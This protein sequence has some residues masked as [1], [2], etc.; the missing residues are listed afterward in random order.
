MLQKPEK[1]SFLCTLHKK[2]PAKLLFFV[3]YSDLNIL[4]ARVTMGLPER[5]RHS[6]PTESGAG[7]SGGKEGSYEKIFLEYD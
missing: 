1:A 5:V 7:R 6:T 3:Q 2:V 4:A